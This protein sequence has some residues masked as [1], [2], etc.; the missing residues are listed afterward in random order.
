MKPLVRAVLI[1]GFVIVAS[2]LI[3]ML[4]INQMYLR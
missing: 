3:F 4:L 2:V 1:L